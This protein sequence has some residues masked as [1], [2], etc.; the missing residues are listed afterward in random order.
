MRALALAVGVA[1]APG[2]QAQQDSSVARPNLLAAMGLLQ[3]EAATVRHARAPDFAISVPSSDEVTAERLDVPQN[4]DDVIAAWEFRTGEGAVVETLTLTVARIDLAEP[5]VRQFAMA[6]LLVLRS[7]AEIAR[8]FPG[9]RLIAFGPVAR[10]D[11]LSAVQTVGNFETGEG[12][13]LVFRHVGL[14]AEGR[15]QALVA[16]VNI[17]PER[18]PVRSDAELVDTFAGRALGS[19]RLVGEGGAQSAD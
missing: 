5:V 13:A 18:M 16:I 7:Y 15:E 6:N 3:S 4:E 17:D 2:A 19:L 9:A 12:R 1:L 14:M 8:Q 10:E 11:G